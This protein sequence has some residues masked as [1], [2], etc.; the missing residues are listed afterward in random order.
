MEEIYISEMSIVFQRTTRRYVP[1]DS[2][3]H[4]RVCE[5]LKSCKNIQ[6]FRHII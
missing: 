1:E 4:N 6:F 3:L 2:T 5:N